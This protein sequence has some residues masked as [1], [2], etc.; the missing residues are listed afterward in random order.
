[1][2]IEM[3]A[4]LLRLDTVRLMKGVLAGTATQHFQD[5]MEAAFGG[6]EPPEVCR[7][8]EG[9][10]EEEEEAEAEEEDQPTTST[11]T[12]SQAMKRKLPPTNLGSA[13]KHKGSHSVKGGICSLQKVDCIYPTTADIENK[14]HTEVDPKFFSR[15]HSSSVTK[16]AGYTCQYSKVLKSE[17]KIVPDCMFFSLV[18]AQL[19]THICQF[20]LGVAVTCYVCQKKWW[21]ATMWYEHMTKIHTDLSSKDYYVKEG[22]NI[23]ESQEAFSLKKEVVEEDL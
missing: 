15:R 20:Y 12:L 9:D 19:G 11:S 22:T 4:S 21:S 5:V 8:F 23:K 17:G 14:L 7:A 2:H 16:E 18:K 10:F 1:M 3:T 13:P 6:E